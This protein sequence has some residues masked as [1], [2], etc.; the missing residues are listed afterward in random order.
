MRGYTHAVIIALLLC[1][2][3]AAPA[4]AQERA[5]T[6]PVESGSV[7]AFAGAAAAAT[8]YT[9]P[10]LVAVPALSAGL[11]APAASA[12]PLAAAAASPAVAMPASAVTLINPASL[13]DKARDYTG[14]EWSKLAA[15]A[16]D[17]GARAVLRSMRGGANP[18]LTV[19][20]ADGESVSGSFLG[21]AGDKMAFS[22]GGRLLGVDM[23]T[24]DITEVL[25]HA[26]A[27]F[28]GTGDL[29]PVDVVVHSRP[30]VVRDPFR[31]LAA[32]QGRYLEIDARDLDDLK[33]SAHT[34]AG[35]LVKADGREVVLEGP[36]G[37]ATLSPEFHRIDAVREREAHYDSRNQVGTLAEV[38]DRILSGTPVELTL[39]GKSVPA[40][41][42]FRGVRSDRD[43]L[44]V[45]L[46]VPD[47]DGATTMR[48][49]RNV[50][51]VRTRGYKAGE[52]MDGATPV[53]AAAAEPARP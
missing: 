53:Y 31:D 50:V 18:W 17:E 27:Y 2:L 24:R 4:R 42:R 28:D 11:S 15:S 12:A 25:R 3:E 23:N 30:A 46:E 33:W 22:S 29:R 52:L 7:A 20:L 47:S 5:E 38:N 51:S 8:P 10:V 39:P 35:R 19:K 6:S 1:V 34:V 49:Y 43:G 48:A 14:S 40:P 9:A 26:D 21:L 41:G 32:Y 36:K 37:R 13:P 16:P 45:L 44:Y